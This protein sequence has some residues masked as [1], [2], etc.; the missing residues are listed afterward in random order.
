VGTESACLLSH[1]LLNLF[2]G[3]KHSRRQQFRAFFV[4]KYMVLEKK[5]LPVESKRWAQ[6]LPF[7]PAGSVAGGRAASRFRRDGFARRHILAL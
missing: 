5:S 3:S 2:G 4:I 7:I 1:L 6:N